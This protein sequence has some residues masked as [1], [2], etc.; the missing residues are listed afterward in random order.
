MVE[1]FVWLEVVAAAAASIFFSPFLSILFRKQHFR[2]QTYSLALLLF[3][4]VVSLR[5]ETRNFSS[6]DF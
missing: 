2:I 5:S 4:G 3:S 6:R 1:V